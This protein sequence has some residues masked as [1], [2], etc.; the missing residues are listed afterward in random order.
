M[1]GVLTTLLIVFISSII[2]ILVGIASKFVIKQNEQLIGLS[3]IAGTFFESISPIVL[4]CSLYFC[5]FARSGMPSIV[6]SCIGFSLC[7]LGYIPYRLN[8]ENSLGKD[9]VVNTVG[10]IAELFKWSFCVNIIGVFDAF[11]T[12]RMLMARTYEYYPMLIL[13]LFTLIVIFALNIIK[14]VLEERM[15]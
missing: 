4:L 7:F 10:L 11:G 9:I 12:I 15:K 2:P 1:S 3:K 13:L 14:L 5:V 6:V 8:S